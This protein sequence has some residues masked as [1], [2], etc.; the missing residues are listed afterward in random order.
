MEIFL[1][2]SFKKEYAKLQPVI[3]ESFKRRRNLF[4]QDSF[5][6]LLN[7]HS[8]DAAYPGCRSINITGDYRVVFRELGE[9]AQFLHIG[10]HS[11]L[12]G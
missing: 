2:K 3:K 12:Y 7:N 1:H 4:L 11:Q 10:T 8:V 9:N 5:N 6:P